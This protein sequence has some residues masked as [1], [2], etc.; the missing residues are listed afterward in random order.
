METVAIVMMSVAYAMAIINIV[1]GMRN[2][3]EAE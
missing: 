1:A 2:R 3:H